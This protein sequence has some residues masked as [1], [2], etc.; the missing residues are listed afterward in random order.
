MRTAFV[1]L[2][3][4]TLAV[5]ELETPPRAPKPVDDVPAAAA[6]EVAAPGETLVGADRLVGH[7]LLDPSPT[8]WTAPP[9]PGGEP[10][11]A[12]AAAPPAPRANAG[13]P[14]VPLSKPRPRIEASRTIDAGANPAR[15]IAVA[16][17]CR[18]NPFDGLLQA[19]NLSSAC[20]T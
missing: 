8:A 14:A 19:L 20:Q 5:M 1:L 11:P 13:R 10:P 12:A 17:S 4:G 2:G 15:S 3:V 18:P 16:K 9:P 7:R 6:V